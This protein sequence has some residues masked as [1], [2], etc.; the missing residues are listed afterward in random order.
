MAEAPFAP[1]RERRGRSAG[2]GLGLS[3]AKGIVEAHGGRIALDA[4]PAGTR[5]V[6]RLPIETGVATVEDAAD[7]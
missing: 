1:H 5:F 4:T 2:A 3:I 6:I 7:A